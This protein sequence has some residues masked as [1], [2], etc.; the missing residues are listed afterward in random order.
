MKSTYSDKFQEQA[1]EKVYQRGNRS[2]RA[3]ASELNVS[4][5][6]LK[7]W[8]KKTGTNSTSGLSQREQRP[9]DWTLEERLT[10][11]QESHG[12]AGEALNAW[13]RERGLFGHHLGEWKAAF[14]QGVGGSDNRTNLRALK[15]ENHRLS[16]ELTRKEKALAEMAAL[17]VLQ[18]K[19]QALWGDEVA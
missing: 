2:I 14:C 17:L 8:M 10:A 19:S 11:L 9:K 16:R 4:Y 1:L 6:T 12:L 18:K 5:H 7:Y 3:V 15:E 13:C